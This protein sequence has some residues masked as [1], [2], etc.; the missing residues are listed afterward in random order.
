MNEPLNPDAEADV[1]GEAATEAAAA[2][3]ARPAV[4]APA[5]PAGTATAATGPAAAHDASPRSRWFIPAFIVGW[6]VIWYGATRALGNARDS[7]PFALVV[8]VVTFDLVHDLVLAPV[9]LLVGWALGRMVPPI[10]RGPVR[11]AA[12][13][14]AI[15]VVF[16]YPL[17]RRWG[18]RPTNSS[19]LPLPYARNIVLV[20]ALVWL[21]AAAVVVTRAR[22]HRNAPPQPAEPSPSSSP[23]PSS[24]A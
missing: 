12:A 4:T 2:V 17:W 1:R 11:A 22:H 13:I 8:H 10:A 24:P 5:H 7:H 21:A 18:H 6:L 15:V 20:L 3:P 9:V 19:T 16:A 14:S 23:A